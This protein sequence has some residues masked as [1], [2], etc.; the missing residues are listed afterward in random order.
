MINS[1]SK[2]LWFGDHLRAPYGAELGQGGR[3]CHRKKLCIKPVA[4]M[5]T[6]T[7]WERRRWW[8][9]RRKDGGRDGKQR[10]GWGGREGRYLFHQS[11]AVTKVL[12]HRQTGKNQNIIFFWFIKIFDI[13]VIMNGNH[14]HR[15][16][17]LSEF[18]LFFSCLT[19]YFIYNECRKDKTDNRFSKAFNTYLFVIILVSLVFVLIIVILINQECRIW[20]QTP[21]NI[22]L[23]IDHNNDNNDI[24]NNKKNITKQGI[25]IYV[26]YSRPNGWTD[27]AEICWGNS[28]EK[29]ELFCSKFFFLN[30]FSTGN[31]GPFS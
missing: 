1:F 16:V 21:R 26:A 7:G 17:K 4:V 8:L 18:L 13:F 27:C 24:D 15:K 14:N 31:A 30:I 22:I 10:I 2:C 12:H 3:I 25:H 9:R 6:V 11:Q 20:F 5:P 29:L 28:C 23:F 19:T